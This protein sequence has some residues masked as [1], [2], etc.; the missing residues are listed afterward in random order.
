MS[1]SHKVSLQEKIQ[2]IYNFT[3]TSFDL[4]IFNLRVYSLRINSFFSCESL[5]FQIFREQK[6][7]GNDLIFIQ[8]MPRANSKK[9]F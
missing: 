9:L 4:I 3:K 8:K 6:N 7:C 1:H 5:S 2:M